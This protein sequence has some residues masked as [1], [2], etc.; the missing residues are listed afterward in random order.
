M[1][2]QSTSS[3]G[4]AAD[5]ERRILS[6]ALTPGA[7]LPSERALADRHALS[8]P[9]VREALRRLAERG[10]V[11]V[12]AGRGS[13]VSS[14]TGLDVG[15]SLNLAYQRRHVTARHIVEARAMLESQAAA[16]AA[17]RADERDLALLSGTLERLEDLEATGDRVEQVR[18][19]LAFH[20]GIARAAHNPVLEVM[21]G[22]IAPLAVE[23]M[24]RSVSDPRTRRKSH[25]YH[26]A[27][28]EAIAA[29]DPAAAATALRDH[30]HVADDTYGPDYDRSL[31]AMAHRA[32]E[33][34]LGPDAS[35]DAF[36]EEL[37]PASD[38]PLPNLPHPELPLDALAPRRV[39]SGQTG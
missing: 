18:L 11:R 30:L 33:G 21:F 3:V 24:L 7:K 16:L 25:P 28:Y 35:L 12:E 17:E 36:V 20:L 15:R 19:D 8:R 34:L 37:L 38:L 14:A 9:M 13:F 27:A 26:R 32:L 2:G 31:D 10:L 4:L 39:G 1:T 6:G 5:L 22:S 23:Q 29:R